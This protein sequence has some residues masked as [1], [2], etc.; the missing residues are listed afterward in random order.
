MEKIKTRTRIG[1]TGELEIG[2]RVA[3]L[4]M[5]VGLIVKAPKSEMASH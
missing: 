2:E 4:N 5:V 1:K 3:I